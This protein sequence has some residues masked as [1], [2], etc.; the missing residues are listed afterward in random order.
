MAM[1]KAIAVNIA[2]NT[3]LTE[4]ILSIASAGFTLAATAFTAIVAARPLLCK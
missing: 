2:G 1:A 4:A 3:A